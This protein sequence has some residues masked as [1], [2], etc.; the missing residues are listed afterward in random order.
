MLLHLL[1]A[2]AKYDGCNEGSFFSGV[3]DS[4]VHL[5]RLVGAISR[6]V[7]Y[8]VVVYV[9]VDVILLMSVCA[10]VCVCVAVL[11]CADWVVVV[12]GRCEG[13]ER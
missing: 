9:K 5:D 8:L 11:L 12:G 2:N 13:K 7:V 1:L 6:I 4:L 3:P 10:R